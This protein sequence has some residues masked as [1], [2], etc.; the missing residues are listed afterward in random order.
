[1]KGLSYPECDPREYLSTCHELGLLNHIF[2]HM[3]HNV[4]F[5]KEIGELKDPT[6]SL[7]WLL[8]DNDPLALKSL[9]KDSDKIRFLV[10]ML[11]ADPEHIDENNL[12]ELLANF[13]KSGLLGR[14]ISKWSVDVGKK[15]PHAIQALL[16]YM[17]S[18]RVKVFHITDNGKAPNEEFADLISPFTGKPDDREGVKKRR[19]SLEHKNFLSILA[20]LMPKNT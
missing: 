14:N 1:M 5:P 20:D 17:D 18:P 10:D 6:M 15:K 9:G 13:L 12:E 16:K 2:P 4:D 7:A 19:K 11:K 8:Q 3:K